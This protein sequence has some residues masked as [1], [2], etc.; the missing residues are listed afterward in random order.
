MGTDDKGQ[1][2]QQTI[3]VGPV[4]AVIPIKMLGTNGGGFYGMNAA[5]PFENPTGLQLRD[6]ARDDAVPVRAGA[7]VRPDA[8]TDPARGGDLRGDDALMIG[9]IVVGD[10]LRHA[11]A[12]SRA[13]TA[14]PEARPIRSP[15]PRA[16]NGR[17]DVVAPE[18][19]GL[20]VDQHLGNLEGKE[21]RFGTSAGATFAAIT[22]DVTCGAINA[23]MDSLNPIAAFRR[24]SACG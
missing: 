5:H 23:E 20:P 18:V 7:D 15:A 4:A 1:A 10:S 13:F 11:E 22:I 8:R 2:K 6:D 9:M 21:L 12:Q 16:P 19:A 14:H 3:I 24:W 17:L